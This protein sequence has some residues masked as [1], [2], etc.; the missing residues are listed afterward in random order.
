MFGS[1]VNKLAAAVR[2]L[3]SP[4]AV[5]SFEPALA[6]D[7]VNGTYRTNNTTQSPEAAFTHT[8]SGNATMVDSDGLLKWG[9][10]N[11]LTYSEDFS[12]WSVNVNATVASDATSAPDGSL[13]ADKVT[14]TSDSFSGVRQ[15][16]D[17]EAE[18]Y[19]YRVWVKADTATSIALYVLQQGAASWTATIDLSTGV[20]TDVGA[21]ITAQL[22]ESTS[23][24][25]LLVEASR[26]FTAAANNHIFGV[27]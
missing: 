7:F 17:I 1:V 21:G 25:W 8:R 13:T 2:R 3:L 24:G 5:G 26:T 9:P 22:I 12:S 11:L 10:H 16:A 20:I 23:D 14:L 19:S 6:Y 27:A 4:Y 15:T 18:A